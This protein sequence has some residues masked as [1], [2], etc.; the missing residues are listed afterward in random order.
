MILKLLNSAELEFHHLIN[1][2]VYVYLYKDHPLATYKEIHFS[3]LA[4]YP[5]LSFEQGDNS[6]FYFAEEIYSTKEYLRTVKVNDRASMLNLMRG[7]N[8]FTLCSGIICEELNGDDYVAVPFKPDKTIFETTVFNYSTICERMQES[9]FLI[10]GLTIEVVDEIDGRSEKYHYENGLEAFCEYLNE[11]KGV[12]HKPLCFTASKDKINVSVAMQY[13]DSYAEN[14]VSFVN[15]VKTSDGG[16]HEVG[17]KTAVKQGDV[18]TDG[19]GANIIYNIY[20]HTGYS[21]GVDANYENERT[22]YRNNK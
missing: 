22:I 5:S 1:C 2:Q 8:G 16:S 21:D 17:F 19:T 4:D 3:D 12:L 7:L 11:N 10:S 14:I 20:S 13:T 9:A 18:K 6:S 15:D